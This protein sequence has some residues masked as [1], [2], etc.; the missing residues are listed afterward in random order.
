LPRDDGSK[1]VLASFSVAPLAW[2]YRDFA[3]V[4][5]GHFEAHVSRLRGLLDELPSP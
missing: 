1:S 2:R 4:N 5:P 3:T